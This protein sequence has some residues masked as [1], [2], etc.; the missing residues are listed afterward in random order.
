[1]HPNTG[2]SLN[3]ARF[4][5]EVNVL[6][7]TSRL[8][9]PPIG[10]DRLRTFNFVKHLGQRHRLTIASFV[11]HERER[12]AAEPYLGLCDKLITVPLPRTK[13]YANCLR[14]LLSAR[15]LQVHYYASPRMQ[16]AVAEEMARQRY[17]VVICHLIRM[18]QY[19]PVDTSVHKVV[20]FTDAMSLF[21]TR[22]APLRRT[23]ALSSLISSVE[24]KRVLRY[25]HETMMKTDESIFISGVDA[26]CFRSS[27]VTSRLGV[28][29][30]GVDL[31]RFPF[32]P[33]D[34]DPNRIV[35]VGNMRTFA[36][37]D[38]VV[39]FVNSILPV[40]K[41]TRPEAT[42]YIV[43][44]QPSKEV[45]AL[46]DGQSVFVTGLVDSVVPY[47]SRAVVQ[48]APMRACAGVQNKI[49]EALAVG[50][51]VVTTTIGAEGLDA[52]LMAVADTP[53]EMARITL[54]LMQDAEKRRRRALTGREY[55]E[56][57]CTW[58]KCLESLDAVLER[59]SSREEESDALLRG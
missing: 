54:E 4:Q 13:S 31:E 10:G 21:Y 58:S 55:V 50:T 44:N 41:R 14:G 11:E 2:R 49:L 48:V 24:S 57:H 18:A 47:L 40:I 38:A 5:S 59:A 1:M 51:P 17:D 34:R 33:T 7:L 3:R 25:E 56:A 6:F 9:F 23:F 8:P 20:D 52:S 30:N 16:A 43:G 53:E 39:F 37:T 19:L 29:S 28:V 36:N 26:D 15:P 42:F 46:H 12:E 27:G 22:S 32:N 35:F 45:R